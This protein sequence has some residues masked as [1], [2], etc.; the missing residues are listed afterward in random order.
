MNDKRERGNETKSKSLS[1]GGSMGHESHEVPLWFV[2]SRNA[3]YYILGVIEILL[4][5]RFIFRIL[6]AN[7]Q[8]AFVSFL[9]SVAS[10]FSTPFSGIFNSFV[11]YGL[12][13]KSVFEPSII[14]GMAVYAVIAW[15]LVGLLSMRL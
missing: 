13:A 10:F 8:N 12:A 3:I 7:S 14:I 15:G 2:K 9:Y 6:G 4:A 11:P 5:F 1:S